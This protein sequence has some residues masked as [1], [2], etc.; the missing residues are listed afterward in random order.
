[1]THSSY[2]RARETISRLKAASFSFMGLRSP[3]LLR[4]TF[5]RFLADTFDQYAR[6]LFKSVEALYLAAPVRLLRK[7]EHAA[8]ERQPC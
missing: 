3:C 5:T 2:S 7:P 1:M 8:V 4:Q 6:Q